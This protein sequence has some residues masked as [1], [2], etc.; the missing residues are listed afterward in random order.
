[1]NIRWKMKERGNS[2]SA[3]HLF[4]F[5]PTTLSFF[6]HNRDVILAQ[7]TQA[8]LQ[9]HHQTEIST[10]L[11]HNK[12]MRQ[13]L[14]AIRIEEIQAKTILLLVGRNPCCTGNHPT[15]HCTPP[16]THQPILHQSRMTMVMVEIEKILLSHTTL[17]QIIRIV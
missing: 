14:S 16:A 7:V 17:K 5:T 2:I 15:L 12:E 4:Q 1:M 6:F 13:L 11:Q 3:F 9:T 8:H 10:N